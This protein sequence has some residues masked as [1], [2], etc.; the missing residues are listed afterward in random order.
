MKKKVSN[1][2]K[3]IAFA[4][5]ISAFLLIPGMGIALPAA[6]QSASSTPGTA[7]PLKIGS[8]DLI[9]I[10]VYD[11]PD[12]SGRFR[13]D[14]KGDI[15]VPLL[16]LVHVEGGT[17]EEVGATIEQRYVDADIIRPSKARAVVFITEYASQGITVT[18]QVKSSGLFPALGVRMLND[19][20][21]AAGGVTPA[22]SSNVIITRKK[23]SGP[24]CSRST[25]TPR[26]LP[27]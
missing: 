2:A 26:R 15:M 25:T 20:I 18:G 5:V 4:A 1:M 7:P 10:T 14:E 21:T 8:G 23:R 19:V 16:G 13:V 22:A 24:S 3:T 6:Q 11:S 12:L 17:A 27:R 9:E